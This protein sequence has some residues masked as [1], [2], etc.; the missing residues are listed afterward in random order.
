MEKKLVLFFVLISLAVT[1]FG[2]RNDPKRN[3]S[4]RELGLYYLNKSKQQRTTGCILLVG[5]TVMTILGIKSLSE[6]WREI[7]ES[8][9]VALVL[10]G[11][12]VVG[13]S[14]A[15]FTYATKNRAR[16]ELLLRYEN[17]PRSLQTP[18]KSGIPALG[19]AVPLGK[20]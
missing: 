6:G 17:I 19:V 9:S 16:A 18:G 7:D 4:D 2:Q 15:P 13:L 11:S 14:A 12:I 10:G 8:G 3:T 5:G 20:R 1:V